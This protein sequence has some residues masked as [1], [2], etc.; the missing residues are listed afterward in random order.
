MALPTAWFQ[1]GSLSKLQETGRLV[2]R[3]PSYRN[4]KGLTRDGDEEKPRLIKTIFGRML[5][6]YN[7]Q[8]CPERERAAV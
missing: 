1:T 5:K 3:H 4:S 8:S 7:T 2:F 6:G